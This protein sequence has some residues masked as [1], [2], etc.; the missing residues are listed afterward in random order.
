MTY[1]NALM[2]HPTDWC[3]FVKVWGTKLLFEKKTCVCKTRMPP[4]ATKPTMA[5]IS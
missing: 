2:N 5:K 4:A 1:V 3:N